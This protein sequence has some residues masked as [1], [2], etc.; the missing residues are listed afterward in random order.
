MVVV[1]L[2]PGLTNA[3][4]GLASAFLDRLPL[5]VIC[6]QHGPDRAPIVVRQSLDNHAL[7][8]PVTKWRAT[9]G[10]RIHQLL[11][12]ALDTALAPPAGPV[13]VELRDDVARAEPDDSP[14]P[15][16][17]LRLQKASHGRHVAPPKA[18]HAD[19]QAEDA[20]PWRHTDSPKASHDEAAEASP[21]VTWCLPK[22]HTP[23]LRPPKCHTGV[24]RTGQERHTTSWKR[25]PGITPTGQ[26]RHTA[27]WTRCAAR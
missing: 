17:P 14:E 7:V 3:I 10:R 16:P 8:T 25:D 27:T 2:A 13:F 5:L 9:A 23:K 1:T 21:S 20:P 26:I 24:T 11:A 19:P 6:G 4:N 15:W 18:S 12:K 22:C